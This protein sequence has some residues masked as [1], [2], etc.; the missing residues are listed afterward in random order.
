M[1][2]GYQNGCKR[3]G[4]L[5]S[6]R[7]VLGVDEAGRGPLAGP[8]AIG[9]VCAEESFDFL[10]AFPGLDDSKQLTE[11]A[12]ERLFAL[13]GERQAA[14]DITYHVELLSH[15]L[16]D[17][18]GIVHAV[19]RGVGKGVRTLLPEPG[20]GKVWLDGSLRAPAAY[21]QETVIRGDSLIPAIML[22]SVAAKVT[23]DRHMVELAQRH[24]G[25]GFEKHKGY[26]TAEHYKA[27]RALGPCAIHRI[28]FVHLDPVA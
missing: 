6:M 22:A 27:L 10:A 3:L 14:G 11:A 2:L 19:R 17:T 26:G 21:E 1:P 23:R 20:G 13:L 18:K 7:Y 28:S 25:Y 16:I 24:P 4:T 8:V 15:R 12:R 9:T 5:G